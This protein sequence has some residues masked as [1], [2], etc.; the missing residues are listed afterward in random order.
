MVRTRGRKITVGDPRDGG[1]W[2]GALI[3]KQ[4]EEKVRSYLK[5]A[6]DEGLKFCCGETVDELVLSAACQKVILSY[7]HSGVFH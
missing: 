5:I 4:H 6:E 7:A 2:M 1:T 3:S